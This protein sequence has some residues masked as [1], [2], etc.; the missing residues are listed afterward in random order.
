MRWLVRMRVRAPW[1]PTTEIYSSE[2]EMLYRFPISL[3]VALTEWWRLEAKITSID[4][5]H[6]RGYSR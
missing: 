1:E 5:K 3:A 6:R 4:T 2:Q